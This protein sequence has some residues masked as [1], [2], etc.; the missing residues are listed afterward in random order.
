M[1]RVKIISDPYR[2]Q[3]NF[4]CEGDAEDDWRPV[5]PGS[6]LLGD[7][8]AHGF[9]PFK[10]KEIVDIIVGDYWTSGN[11][12]SIVFEGASDEYGELEAICA[13]ARYADT[14]RLSQSARRLSNARDILP[15]IIALFHELTPFL[16]E[17]VRDHSKIDNDLRK[18]SD[19]SSDAVPICVMGNYSAGKS[20]FINALIGAELLPNGDEPT[21]ARIY[22]IQH[23]QRDEA[24]RIDFSYDG[25]DVS[26]RFGTNG[27]SSPKGEGDLPILDAVR[28][29]AEAASGGFVRQ[30][31]AALR[32]INDCVSLEGQGR[33]SDLVRIELPLSDVDPWAQSGN[34]VIFDTPGS[35]SATH[36]DHLRV[37]R[38]AMQSMSNG[39]PVYVSQYDSLDSIDNRSLYDEIKKIEALDSRFAMIVVNKAD[40]ASLPKGGLSAEDEAQILHQAVPAHMYSQGIYFI[41][42]IVGLGAKV[43]GQFSS[44]YYAEKFEDQ[45]RKYADPSESYYKSLY[46]YDIMPEQI[47][48][49][50]VTESRACENLMLANSGL[51]ALERA[52]QT[53][54]CRYS[55]YN[56][57]YQSRQSLDRII[58]I[59]QEELSLTKEDCERSRNQR[60]KVL[61][62]DR[63]AL[64]RQLEA[65]E[66]ELREEQVSSFREALLPVADDVCKTLRPDDLS[67]KEESL[68]AKEKERLG[69]DELAERV[70]QAHGAVF[71]NLTSRARAFA[72]DEGG[73]SSDQEDG[74]VEK[75]GAMGDVREARNASRSRQ[76][77][78]SR[79]TR[80]ATDKLLAQ[81]E[82]LLVSRLRKANETITLRSREYWEDASKSSRQALYELVSGSTEIDEGVRQELAD[83]IAD[84]RPL[85]LS[86]PSVEYFDKE[87]MHGLWLGNFRLIRSDRLNIP[88]VSKVYGRTVRQVVHDEI[89]PRVEESHRQSFV[90]WLQELLALCSKNIISYNPSL[91][92]QAQIIEEDTRR[93]AELESGIDM[94]KRCRSQISLMLDW[95]DEVF[96]YGD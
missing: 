76:E 81:L 10:V 25:T 48:A 45:Q 89:F 2:K 85:E 12:V 7:S 54:A 59:T 19:A 1:S 6:K 3:T 82:G 90:L 78:L 37:L 63:E 51:Y 43:D 75:T 86:Q 69:Y 5:N 57:C 64:L 55:S 32:V 96:A 4:Q 39:V 15:D 34:F 67:Q 42:S 33:V 26:L 14:V 13:D 11:P 66:A 79:A 84:Y 24:G 28:S 94:L 62:D 74:P 80:G 93:I 47:K 91:K 21:T 29:A 56:K 31:N 40:I 65:R 68:I 92:S 38:D 16:T 46:L 22:Q 50:A 58:D 52:M 49:R 53:F 83:V 20:T 35:N 27:L 87:R 95:K 71:G 9:F 41:S 18:F 30:M 88:K 73:T 60:N 61:E 8:I 36:A 72:E 44:D 70:R 77:L 23:S 17:H